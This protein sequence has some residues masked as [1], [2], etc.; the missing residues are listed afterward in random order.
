MLEDKLMHSK[1]R[2]SAQPK[3]F[4]PRLACFDISDRALAIS[5]PSSTTIRSFNLVNLA[6]T[7][8]L[9]KRGLLWTRPTILQKP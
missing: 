9:R 2:L 7:E 8:W 3:Q 5:S 6:C 4:S 1:T